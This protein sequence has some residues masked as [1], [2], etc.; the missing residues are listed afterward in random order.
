MEDC[1]GKHIPVPVSIELSADQSPAVGSAEQLEMR[2]D[3]ALYRTIVGTLIYL[4]V[5]SRPDIAYAVGLLSRFMS[6]PGQAHMAVAKHV[7]RYLQ[8]TKDTVFIQWTKSTG[9][10]QLRF[11]VDA[12]W[13]TVLEDRTSV[14]GFFGVLCGG[15]VSWVSKKQVTV[16]LSS[17]ESEY[18]AAAHCAQEAVYS[19]RM[20]VWLGVPQSGPTVLSEDNQAC[21][22]LSRDQGVLH[23]RTKHIDIR[24]HFLRQLVQRGEIVLVHIS[25]KLQTAD[26]LTKALSREIFETHRS[27]LMGMGGIV[28]LVSTECACSMCGF[29]IYL[30]ILT[31]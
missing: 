27:V 4:M 20:L 3:Q 19:R 10:S 16:S 6:N 7:C 21:I 12:T 1:H 14:T 28:L 31:V 17:A 25:T 29:F 30:L 8:Q 13:A 15:P 23:A 2:S 22:A 9:S 24:H 26:M 5:G 11:M 18:M